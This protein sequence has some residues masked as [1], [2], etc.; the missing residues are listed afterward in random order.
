MA[1][2]WLGF[3]ILAASQAVFSMK[4]EGMHHAWIRLFLITSVAWFPWALVT[5]L[6]SRLAR[7]FPLAR[8]W[9][10]HLV[11]CVT[12]GAAY[13]AWN[14]WLEVLFNPY[15]YATLP[16]F[17]PAFTGHFFN[18]IV[19]ALVLYGA[20]LAVSSVIDSRDRLHAQ[21]TE[22]ARLNEQLSLAQLDALR[23]QIEPHFLFNTLN[24]IAALVREHRNSDAI[25]MVA[26]LSDLLRRSLDTAPL[27]QVSL[28]EEVAFVRKYLDIQKMRFADRL[29]IQLEV[30]SE[31]NDARVPSLILQP[32]VE[33]AVK[34]G[35]AQR[36]QGGMIRITAS[37]AAET[38]TLRI[39]D[40]GPGLAPGWQGSTTGIGIANVR[41]RLQSFYGDAS[42]LDLHNQPTGGVEVAM[43]LPLLMPEA[44]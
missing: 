27:Q 13:S 34:H 6:I 32:V 20:I 11:F 36:A 38:L 18:E 39:T 5:P 21:Q 4:S 37:R 15:A 23:R 42:T 16:R 26:G 22:T 14:A 10:I 33:N 31:L 28:H 44:A 8:A 17:A 35:I 19:S 40:D 43:T 9:P 1:S 30:P 29:Q 2:I 3:G 7:L 25:D 24:S 12:I 41:T